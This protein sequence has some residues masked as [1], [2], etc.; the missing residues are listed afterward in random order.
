MN[1]EITENVQSAIRPGP[2]F[3]SYYYGETNQ[4][5]QAFSCIVNNKFKQNF[6]TMGQGTSQFV[7]SPYQG[8]SDII[9]YFKLPS[10]ASVANAVLP[11]GWGYNLI[12]QVSVRYGSSS[13]YFFTGEQIYLSNLFD[14]ED[15]MKRDQLSAL[16]GNFWNPAITSVTQPEAYVYLK[17]PHNSPRA[18]GKPNP[19][20]TDLN[21]A[22]IAA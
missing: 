22:A 16:G 12:N 10:V 19:F 1:Y 20:P 9:L 3:D 5:K 6:A 14:C 11:Q 21:I 4:E 17:L 8:V 18:D 7:I 15:S 13:Q 2:E